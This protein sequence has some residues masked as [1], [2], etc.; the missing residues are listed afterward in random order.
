MT[1]NRPKLLRAIFSQG[2]RTPDLRHEQP[3][4]VVT[5]DEFFIGNTDDESIAVN[6]SDHPGVQ[7]FYERLRAIQARPDVKTVL[8]NIYDLEPIIYG[9]WPYAENVHVLTCASED[10]VQSWATELRSDG[11]AEGWPYGKP[12]AAAKPEGGYRWW[13]MSW[14]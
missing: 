1:D 14:D 13:W 5:I 2:Y 11:A 3:P 10:Q 12:E 7:F 9:G 6:L 4:P 8:V